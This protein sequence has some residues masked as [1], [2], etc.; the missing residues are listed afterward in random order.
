MAHPALVRPTRALID[1]LMERHAHED[2]PT[3]YSDRRWLVRE[4]FCLA[5]V[6][7]ALGAWLDRARLVPALWV[8]L[9]AG[10]LRP[11]TEGTPLVWVLPALGTS[12]GAATASSTPTRPPASRS[13]ASTRRRRTMST[14]P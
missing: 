3:V 7:L 1:E 5:A 14:G 6:G 2:T 10:Y 9:V 8:L 4:L 12:T 11:W 13:V